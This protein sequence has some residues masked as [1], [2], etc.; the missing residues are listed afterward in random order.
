MLGMCFKSQVNCESAKKTD[1]GL[2]RQHLSTANTQCW[3]NAGLALQTMANIKPALIQR[4]ALCLLGDCIRLLI[5]LIQP[6]E[7]VTYHF[8]I[9]IIRK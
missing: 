8:R 2:L 9:Q 7:D 1:I 5:I 3:L 4:L 6:F